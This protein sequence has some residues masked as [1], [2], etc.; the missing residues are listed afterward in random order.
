MV[1]GSQ[2]PKDMWDVLCQHFERKTVS[3]KVYTLMQLYGMCM[4]KDTQI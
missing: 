1:M 2:T 3:N 4:K